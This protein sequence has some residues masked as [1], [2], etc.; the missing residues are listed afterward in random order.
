MPAEKH[1][2]EDAAPL[3]NHDKYVR[4]AL[5]LRPVDE[6]GNTVQLRDL[7]IADF[8]QIAATFTFQ[9]AVLLKKNAH[10]AAGAFRSRMLTAM[11][12]LSIHMV[13]AAV[14]GDLRFSTII[15]PVK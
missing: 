1:P 9:P 6:N 3:M 5:C 15:P 2:F 7:K 13:E 10:V 8:E 12:A 11:E 4:F 14:R